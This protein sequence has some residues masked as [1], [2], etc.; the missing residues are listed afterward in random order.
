MN[1]K[2]KCLGSFGLNYTISFTWVHVPPAVCICV[3]V[4]VSNW[5]N[6]TIQ[7]WFSNSIVV[8]RFYLVYKMW[9]KKTP[10]MTTSNRTKERMNEEK[11][12]LKL[13]QTTN[14][15]LTTFP[16]YD[17][18][19]RASIE[20]R[21]TLWLSWKNKRTK[22]IR[23]SLILCLR[24]RGEKKTFVQHRHWILSGARECELTKYRTETM[25]KRW[26]DWEIKYISIRR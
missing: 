17:F 1:H 21:N 9:R 11:E 13:K 20:W 5:R 15:H 12:K 18:G 2:P 3:Y 25:T 24:K 14:W 7:K 10:K 26:T 23:C 19:T 16:L 8:N 4:F 6:W 22:T